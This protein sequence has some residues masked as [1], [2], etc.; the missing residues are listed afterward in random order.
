MTMDQQ[1]VP[2]AQHLLDAGLVTKEQ[3]E[4]AQRE[5]ERGGGHL[6]QILVQLGLVD[7]QVLASFLARQAG[8]RSVNLDRISRG[9][10]SAGHSPPGGGAP[11]RGDAPL[12]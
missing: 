10:E 7:A 12:P 8:T 11:L 6:A 4:L 1:R 9:P 5:Q 2:L 3:L